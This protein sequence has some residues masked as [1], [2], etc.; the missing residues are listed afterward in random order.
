MSTRSGP[1]FVGGLDR[2]GT[3]LMYALLASHPDV[4]MS[5]RTNWWTYFYDRFGDLR[6]DK[7]LDRCLSVMARYRRHRKLEPDFEQLRRD[8]VGGQRTYGRLF[9]LL[10]EQ[11]A[12][13][14]GRPRWGDK[15]LHTERYADLVLREFADARILHMVR[16][17][18]DRYASVI[19][20]WK[21]VR[22]GVGAGTAAW[23]ASVRLAERNTSN[24]PERYRIVRYEDLVTDPEGV[25]RDL[26]RFL[27]LPFVPAML[28]LEGDAAFGATMNSSYG[29]IPSGTITA[30]SVG[31]FRGVLRPDEIAFMQA[32][33]GREM[34]RLGYA[35][36]P[37]PFT[38][39]ARLHYLARS[40]V[41]GGLMVAWQA[42]ERLYDIVGRDPSAHTLVSEELQ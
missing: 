12:E 9:A 24:H 18:R 8:F 10:K 30:A 11:H 19:R 14:L 38:G 40:A 33:A 22:G 21:R 27:D 20:R 13:R 32:R 4:A 39:A 7:N 34:E 36:E 17:P 41:H 25:V 26:C 37:V 5:R 42:R 29:A 23:L 6:D 28:G 35:L 15:S 2:T 1:I 16:D 31:R 3:S